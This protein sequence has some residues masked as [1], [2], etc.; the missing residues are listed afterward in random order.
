MQ[1][2]LKKFS[3]DNVQMSR[4]QSEDPDFAIVELWAFSEGNN[5][6]RNPIT[7]EVLEE[8][9]DTFKG[10]FIVAKYDKFTKD[11]TTHLPEEVIVGYVSP[12]DNVEFKI[13]EVDGEERE[14]VV[15]KGVLSKVYAEEVVD[16]FRTH[17]ERSVSC[18]FK[19]STLYEENE[20]GEPIDEFGMRLECDNP[21]LAYHIFGI[22]ILGLSVAPSIKS[23][24]I[25]VKKFMEKS[26][27]TMKQL[28]EQ[29]KD[30][31]KL[32]SHPIDKSKEAVDMGDWNGDKAKDDLLKEKN[33]TTLAKSVCLL[34]EKGWGD[35]KKTALK[36]PV[37]NLKDGK[38]V[39]NAEGLSSARAYGEQ[40]DKAVADKVIS[41]QK[42]LGLYKD[43]KED[44]M[45][46]NKKF[47]ESE[48]EKD[49]IMEEEKEMSDDTEKEMAEDTCV[50]T[51]MSEN[52]KEDGHDVDARID[53]DDDE[54]EEREEVAKEEKK[55]SLDA[56]VDEVAIMEMLEKETKENKEL[57]DKVMKEMSANDIVKS[58]MEMS[59]E[60]A[61]LR[62]EKEARD[63]EDRDK[64]F[65]AIMASVKED[66]D[67]KKFAELSEEGKN[68]SLAELGAFENKVKAF[69]YEAS[70]ANPRKSDDDVMRFAGVDS[71]LNNEAD[72]DVFVRISKM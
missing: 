19:C 54:D 17:N 11:A 25:K 31:L 35:R 43:N 5:T 13:K 56:Y 71:S 48:S 46:E 2:Y 42:R 41:I 23:T 6:H 15:V 40:H 55:F 22:T 9:S 32:V 14:F 62:V 1:E 21:I 65:S 12:I 63:K 70:K 64:K 47:S 36:Y 39:Y 68:L 66:L 24:E 50:E 49:V 20:Y 3:V 44:N 69:A 18:E 28:A 4:E 26:K 27:P 38:W 60:M 37:M 45:E 67:V 51:E 57:A 7:R 72:E 58:F 29:R 10:K 53:D 8:Y 61:E 33:F 59:K 30:K 34:L 16:M 52:E